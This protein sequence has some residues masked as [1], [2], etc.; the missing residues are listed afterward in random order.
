[1]PD[2]TPAFIVNNLIETYFDPSVLN[3]VAPLSNDWFEVSPPS[4][5]AMIWPPLFGS[6]RPPNLEISHL[7]AKFTSFG[8]RGYMGHP[9][10]KRGSRWKICI[11]H[12]NIKRQKN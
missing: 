4:D 12:A 2:C 10:P 7:S 5:S 9:S 1:M 8:G 3:G 11:P 6:K